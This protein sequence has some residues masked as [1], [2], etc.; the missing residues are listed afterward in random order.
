MYGMLQCTYRVVFCLCHV[1]AFQQHHVSTGT[2]IGQERVVKQPG[3]GPGEGE[4][5]GGRSAA[6]AVRAYGDMKSQ[7][8]VWGDG[9]QSCSSCG[10]S[11]CMRHCHASL[12]SLTNIQ[13]HMSH[14]H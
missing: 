14:W 8:Q 4:Q 6:S 3:Q 5:A 1:E 2:G 11:C 9:F 7:L 13:P 10:E 12:R